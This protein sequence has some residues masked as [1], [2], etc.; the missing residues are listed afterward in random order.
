MKLNERT[1]HAFQVYAL[2]HVFEVLMRLTKL[3]KPVKWRL[4][5]QLSH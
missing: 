3:I 2:L 4:C 5:L 1:L